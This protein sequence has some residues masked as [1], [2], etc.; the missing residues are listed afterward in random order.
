MYEDANEEPFM[1]RNLNADMDIDLPPVADSP[2]TSPNPYGTSADWDTQLDEQTQPATQ[3][4]TQPSTQ[5][6]DSLA[7]GTAATGAS[8][9]VTDRNYTLKFV[10]SSNRLVGKNGVVI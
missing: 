5:V 8:S 9:I 4:A 3:I 1:T 7:L 10:S 2:H 6:D